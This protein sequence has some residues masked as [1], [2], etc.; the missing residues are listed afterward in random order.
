[1][2][3]LTIL[4]AILII[5]ALSCEKDTGCWECTVTIRTTC[6]DTQSGYASGGGTTH[7]TKATSTVCDVSSDDINAL[8]KSWNTTATSTAGSIICTARSSGTCKKQ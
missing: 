3:K 1:M 2:K 5:F 4:I 7:V 8:E 6:E